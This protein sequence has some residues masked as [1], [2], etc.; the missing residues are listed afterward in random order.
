MNWRMFIFRHWKIAL[1]LL[2]IALLSLA[3]SVG[4]TH[5]EPIDSPV[6]P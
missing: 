1:L 3:I 5:A 4:K 2:Q 6:G